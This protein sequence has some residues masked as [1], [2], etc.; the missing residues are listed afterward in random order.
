MQKNTNNPHIVDNLFRSVLPEKCECDPPKRLEKTKW[1]TKRSKIAIEV[2]QE[3]NV[4]NSVQKCIIWPEMA[5]KRPTTQAF[6]LL[7]DPAI[8]RSKRM[9]LC[10][11]I[12][13]LYGRFAQQFWGNPNCKLLFM[14]WWIR[15]F[16]NASISCTSKFDELNWV[17]YLTVNDRR[18][19]SMTAVDDRVDDRRQ[20]PSMTVDDRCR[21]PSMTVNDCP[22][23]VFTN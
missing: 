10:L 1:K 7:S 20:W 2:T 23:R 13:R 19:P 14:I 3:G 9:E 11:R 17:R 16:S 15:N 4:E 21:W 5:Q 8:F 18:W 22:M 6:S 12:S